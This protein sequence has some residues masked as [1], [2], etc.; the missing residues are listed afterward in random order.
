MSDAIRYTKEELEL[1]NH[2]MSTRSE[3]LKEETLKESN[4]SNFKSFVKELEKLSKKYGVAIQ[5][6]GGVKFA[7]IDRIKYND[8]DTSGDL[9]YKMTTKK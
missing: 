7:D 2:Y 1:A 5:A 8:D 6:I 9:E 3:S 4:G